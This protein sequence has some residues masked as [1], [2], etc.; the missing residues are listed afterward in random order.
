MNLLK[1]KKEL[2]KNVA[3]NVSVIDKLENV[4][5]SLLL[6]WI[7]IENAIFISKAVKTMKRIWWETIPKEKDNLEKHFHF[8]AFQ[9][10]SYKNMHLVKDP[11]FVWYGKRVLIQNEA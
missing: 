3:S 8:G 5:H 2:I 6:F 7:L 9:I 10:I 1:K 11:K 4:F